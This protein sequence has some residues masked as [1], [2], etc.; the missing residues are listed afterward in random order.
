MRRM[1][2]GN[3]F[4]RAITKCS[5]KHSRHTT[6]RS[7]IMSLMHTEWRNNWATESSG[8]SSVCRRYSRASWHPSFGSSVYNWRM[9]VRWWWGMLGLD[10][11]THSHL[12]TLLR[13]AD[14]DLIHILHSV[15]T[16]VTTPQLCLLSCKTT[17]NFY[18]FLKPNPSESPNCDQ[19]HVTK[20][21]YSTSLY[22]FS[23]INRIII[24][25]WVY[26]NI[27]LTIWKKQIFLKWNFTTK[28][29]HAVFYHHLKLDDKFENVYFT[30]VK[31][32]Q[33]LRSPPG[34]RSPVCSRS[35]KSHLW[36]F[37]YKIP[38]CFEL[39]SWYHNSV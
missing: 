30:I 4:V 22:N 32:V 36:V 23:I 17:T 5:S 35:V 38:G 39:S 29:Q 14:C 2:W 24:W 20:M 18:P 7:L 13:K 12:M 26:I 27:N 33:Y 3:N 34:D 10:A 16:I 6:W 21:K 31:D 28:Y 37:Q 11:P 1:T 19:M 25:L 15:V 8:G 9:L